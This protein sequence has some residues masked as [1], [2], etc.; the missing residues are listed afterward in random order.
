V[1]TLLYQIA[2]EI[3]EEQAR[4]VEVEYQVELCDELRIRE[5]RTYFRLPFKE[6]AL[7]QTVDDGTK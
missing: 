1:D 6:G 2:L 3:F 7:S 5:G 4:E